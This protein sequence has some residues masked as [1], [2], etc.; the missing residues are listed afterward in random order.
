MRG[1]LNAALSSLQVVNPAPRSDSVH[2]SCS[3]LE[4]DGSWRR[5]QGSSGRWIVFGNQRALFREQ[6]GAETS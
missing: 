4:E 6:A 3:L 1:A 2:L 5:S